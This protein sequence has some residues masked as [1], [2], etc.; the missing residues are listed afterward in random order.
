VGG[1]VVLCEVPE[2]GHV[3]V[4]DGLQLGVLHHAWNNTADWPPI[5][6]QLP[7]LPGQARYWGKD[8]EGKATCRLH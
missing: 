6:L 5:H 7:A 4:V 8:F 3:A 1:E 2:A